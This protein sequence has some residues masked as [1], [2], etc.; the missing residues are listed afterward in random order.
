MWHLRCCHCQTVVIVLCVTSVLLSLLE[1][2]YCFMCDI[3][4]AVIVRQWLLSCVWHLCC[5]NCQTQWLLCVT[6]VFLS[7]SNTVF[8]VLCVTSV[9]LCRRTGSSSCTSPGTLMSQFLSATVTVGWPPGECLLST[10]ENSLLPYIYVCT[11]LRIRT[12]FFYCSNCIDVAMSRHCWC[13][14]V[15]HILMWH[16]LTSVDVALSQ[17]C[18]CDIA[19]PL[20]M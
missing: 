17:L 2:G 4:V 9:L 20:L 16:C 19:L 18:W 7:L 15:S 3:C 14:I 10:R 13:D 12:M 8:V 5:C 1:N 6:S 11:T